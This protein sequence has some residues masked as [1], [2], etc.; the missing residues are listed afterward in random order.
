MSKCIILA[1]N[2]LIMFFRNCI[3][4]Y[5][6]FKLLN[7]AESK[8]TED[9]N[10]GFSTSL[11]L[12]NKSDASLWILRELA[13]LAGNLSGL[14]WDLAEPVSLTKYSE[15][16]NYELHFDSEF[17]MEG[18]EMKRAATF[19]LYLNS[20]S[21]G[22]ETIFPR[23]IN[24]SDVDPTSIPN[25]KPLLREICHNDNVLKVA[26]EARSCL[27]FFN[28]LTEEKGG[29]LN[30]RSIHGSCPVVNQEKWIAQIWLHHEPWGSGVTDFW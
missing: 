18:K 2:P 11:Y 21:N 23:S 15:D 3:T 13:L 19:L 29:G 17:M 25:D 16:Q 10:S 20:V 5:H 14:P 6:Q 27:V 4:T 8:F 1:K 28:H 12:R 7:L 9:A 26:P 22:G 24:E 30:R